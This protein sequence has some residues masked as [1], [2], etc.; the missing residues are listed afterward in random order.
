M[1]YCLWMTLLQLRK[2]THCLPTGDQNKHTPLKQHILYRWVY[3]VHLLQMHREGFVWPNTFITPN[4]PWLPI[5][6][7]KLLS[8]NMPVHS[9]EIYWWA[10]HNYSCALLISEFHY[11]AL[12]LL[13]QRNCEPDVVEAHATALNWTDT[14]L[15]I[16][17]AKTDFSETFQPQGSSSV[18]N[19]W[20]RPSRSKRLTK[21]CLC[22]VNAQESI[23]STMSLYSIMPVHDF[24]SSSAQTADS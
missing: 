5:N 10:I 24:F 7:K 11:Y 20:R 21:I 13:Y 22:Y 12:S 23:R 9:S 17:V 15:S 1:T 4:P 6:C 14:F 3:S 19:N 8:D 16:H 2:G 18:T